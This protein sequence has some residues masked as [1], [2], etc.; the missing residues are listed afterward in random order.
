M[1]GQL[2]LVYHNASD[3]LYVHIADGVA[4]RT[5]TTEEGHAVRLGPGGTL[6]SLKIADALWRAGREGGLSIDL[7]S[8]RWWMG[9]AAST[10]GAASAAGK[11]VRMVSLRPL[12][13]SNREAAE[14]LRVAPGQERFVG[15]VADS[16]P[17]SAPGRACSC[18]DGPWRRPRPPVGFVM[19][20]DEVDCPEY[21]PHCLWKLLIDERWQRQGLD[22]AALDLVVE[23]FR[24]RP[25]VEVL[26]AHAGQGEGSPMGFYERYGF[27]WVG[28]VEV[29]EVL[30]RFRL[31]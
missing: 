28:E 7:P 16:L 23:H 24:G 12:T 18:V 6:L 19:T 25:E 1:S 31:P 30:L 13:A 20:A 22:T 10:V 2:Q 4:T 8:G 11:V 29:G 3:V 17:G 26:S 5:M 15:A 9:G 14:A 27:E 21:V